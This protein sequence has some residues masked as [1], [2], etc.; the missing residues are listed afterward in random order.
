MTRRDFPLAIA[1][2][3]L[4]ARP[5]AAEDARTILAKVAELYPSLHSYTF[6]GTAITEITIKGKVSQTSLSFTVAYQEPDKFRLEFRYPNAGNWLRVSDGL[7]LLEVRSVTKE[8]SRTPITPFTIRA[9]N[10]S[11]IANFERLFKTAE[12]PT[13]LRAEA[14]EV[15]G[16]EIPCDVIQFRSHRRELR[17]NESPG[18]SRAWI[19]KDTGLVLSEEIR[20]SASMKGETSE[21]KRTTTIANFQINE[22]ISHETF[23]TKLPRK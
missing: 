4:A 17:E 13:V 21:S 10:S 9:L 7:F 19:A 20:T 18:L 2:I 14:I 8:S 3:T 5:L 23:S 12:S 16:R 11:P 15:A 22:A 6:E 1:S